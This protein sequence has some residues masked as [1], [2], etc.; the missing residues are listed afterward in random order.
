[1]AYTKE[2]KAA[3]DREYRAK[4]A[5]R[6]RQRKAEAFQRDY[7]PDAAAVIRKQRMPYHINYCRQPKYCAKKKEYD[8]KIRAA[9][10]GEFADSYLL[11]LEILKEIRIQ[12]PNREDRYRQSQR[13]GWSPLTHQ[14][15]RQ[16]REEERARKLGRDCISK[17]VDG[18]KSKTRIMVYTERPARQKDTSR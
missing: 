6:I 9:V 3:Y 10:Y 8:L 12:E 1:M 14:K 15:R 16:K 7:N 4:N 13:H 17:G 2:E 18:G 11:L 5:G